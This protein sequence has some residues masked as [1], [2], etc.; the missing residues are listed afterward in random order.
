MVYGNVDLFVKWRKSRIIACVIL[1]PSGRA[2]SYLYVG[3]G[4]AFFFLPKAP[5]LSLWLGPSCAFWC[6][7]S[8]VYP[9]TGLPNASSP[10]PS[11]YTLSAWKELFSRDH[12]AM[13]R[14]GGFL[15]R[16]PLVFH[17][18]DFL[19]LSPCASKGAV[20]RS[21]RPKNA[22]NCYT[23]TII[24]LSKCWALVGVICVYQGH[25]ASY[26]PNPSNSP[27]FKHC[28]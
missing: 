23:Q 24:F 18:G 13:S 26:S 9:I 16:A 6:F 5:F 17:Q 8:E 27:M 22:E 20:E 7:W 3:G 28:M 1:F 25:V 12:G 10:C 11:L 4:E 2:L 19:S 15:K 21:G 14:F